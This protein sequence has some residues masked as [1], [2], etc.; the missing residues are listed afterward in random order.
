MSVKKLIISLIFYV[1]F[2]TKVKIRARTIEMASDPTE[3][4]RALNTTIQHCVEQQD[5]AKK[6]LQ[7]CKQRL[8]YANN[9][10]LT[11]VGED[12]VVVLNLIESLKFSIQSIEKNISQY[13]IMM[14]HSVGQRD[15]ILNMV[16]R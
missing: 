15:A 4:I 1:R 5:Y 2:A 13:Q 14:N 16:G 12:K 8:E 3:R 6:N 7:D 11:L 9:R 10:L